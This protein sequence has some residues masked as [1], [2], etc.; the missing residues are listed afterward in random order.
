MNRRSTS[1]INDKL[2][3][4]ELNIECIEVRNP[5][6]I[7]ICK[8]TNIE[9]SMLW[10][11]MS[12][13]KCCIVCQIKQMEDKLNIKFNSN[14]KNDGGL[15]IKHNWKWICNA[16][17]KNIETIISPDACT[18]SGEICD[19]LKQ[20]LEQRNKQKI[21]EKGKRYRE[22]H[23]DDED[24]KE[25]KRA[26][27]KERLENLTEEQ[28]EKLREKK[29]ED[30]RRRRADPEVKEKENAKKREQYDKM[31]SLRN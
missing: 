9:F 25:K 2:R 27:D 17:G 10:S 23:K 28:K 21:S 20:K 22:A 3:E 30:A 31:K 7:Y 1:G 13:A 14:Y 18:L 15:V 24:Y 11:L 6:D 8:D 26:I 12:K 5:S 29:R 4:K 19:C 16:C